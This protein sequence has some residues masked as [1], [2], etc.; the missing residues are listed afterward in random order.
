[1]WLTAGLWGWLAGGALLIGAALGWFVKLPLRITAVVMAF[2][3]GV[4]LSALSFDLLEEAHQHGGLAATAVGF[5]RIR[6]VAVLSQPC[7]I[8]GR[9]RFTITAGFSTSWMPALAS[10]A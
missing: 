7:A 9:M 1:M 2:G 10:V 6:S 4:L 8:S 5:R 3:S